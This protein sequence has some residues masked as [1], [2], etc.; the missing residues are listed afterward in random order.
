MRKV[1]ARSEPRA[2]MKY[3]LR[4]Y[5]GRRIATSVAMRQLAVC[6]ICPTESAQRP[7]AHIR[8]HHGAAMSNIFACMAVHED[9]L[10]GST[11]I[12]TLLNRRYLHYLV[13]LGIQ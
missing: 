3:M 8:H 5:I 13:D 12:A 4:V 11:N 7:R 6:G 1:D 10:Y 9:S 2:R